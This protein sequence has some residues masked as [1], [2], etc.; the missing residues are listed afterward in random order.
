METKNE[1]H[2]AEYCRV[3]NQVRA[4]T[5]KLQK[6]YELKL[7]KAVWKYIN[8]KTRTRECVSDLSIDPQDDKSRLT[9]CD[10]EKADILGK[11]FSSVFTVEPSGD[12]PAMLR[13]D[14]QSE[15]TNL[16][17]DEV[18]IKDKLER[19]NVCKSVG[20]DGIHPRQ[21]QHICKPLHKI[22]NK[23]LTEWQL[24]DDWKQANLSAIFKRKGNRKKAGNY[25]PVSLTCIMCKILEGCIR[26]HILEHMMVK[27]TYL[28]RNNLGLL[29]AVQQFYNF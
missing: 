14:V 11:F 17:V 10:K 27:L 16:V 19:L 20:P 25:R 6:Q 12:I 26:D 2:Y 28:V 24:P 18:T 3:R 1:K 9:N 21:C 29:K 15:M 8:S 5:R 4:V 13:P 22:F 7:A 23:S